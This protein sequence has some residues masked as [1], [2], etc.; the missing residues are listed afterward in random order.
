LGEGEATDVD[1]P[2]T[3]EVLRVLQR[4]CE[5]G[6][7]NYRIMSETWIFLFLPDPAEF[8][9]RSLEVIKAASPPSI[10]PFDRCFIGNTM[11]LVLEIGATANVEGA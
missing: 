2:Q 7:K 6:K 1:N 3:D 9:R 8:T 11:G 10:A 5:S 4:H